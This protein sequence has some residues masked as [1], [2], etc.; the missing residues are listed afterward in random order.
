MARVQSA[1][2]A[3]DLDRKAAHLEAEGRKRLVYWFPSSGLGC[4]ELSLR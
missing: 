3:L 2:A 4:A 1:E